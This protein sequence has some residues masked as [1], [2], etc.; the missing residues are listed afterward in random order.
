MTPQEWGRVRELFEELVD[1][2]AAEVQRR[3]DATGATDP[4]T[5]AQVRSLLDH[6][7]HA[8][9]FLDPA[10]L[11]VP[12]LD[13]VIETG[14]E[15]GPYIVVREIGH[16]GMGRVYLARDTRLE[17]MVC[18]KVLRHE[19]STDPLYRERLR[20]EARLAASLTDPGICAVYALE[21]LDSNVYVVTE[22]VE[23]HTL[24]EEIRPGS[25]PSAEA[26]IQTARSLA[27]GLA[28][29]HAK[30]ITHRDLK[31]EN[32]MRGADGRL[33]ILDFG[34]ARVDDA[35]RQGRMAATLPGTIVGTPAYM[36]PEQL[37]GKPADPRSDVFALGVV[38]YEY[39]TATHPFAAPSALAVAARILEQEPEPLR[40][41]RP[42]LP[43][44]FSKAIDR[45]L[46]KEAG[47]RFATAADL[48]NA[49]ENDAASVAR[50]T[51]AG[52]T[53]WK[54]HQFATI[55]IYL[56]A[57]GLAWQIKE[58]EP[59]APGRWAFLAIAFLAAFGGILRGHLLF[60]ESAHPHRLGLERART[61]AACVTVDLAMTIV[62]LFGAFL[63]SAS[64]PVVSA[65]T[66]GLAVTI[67]AATVF[68]EPATS[69][70]T[71]ETDE[72]ELRD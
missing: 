11:D 65:L 4:E 28:A 9:S 18:I 14:A 41:R 19:F 15:I 62:L 53:W 37:T 50:P 20:R 6:H 8:G 22:F 46:T 33:K 72:Q 49:L 67:A 32:I 64:R 40:R 57:C 17:R 58:W 7:S 71:F 26:V 1:R 43:Q 10:T 27:T 52:R 31:P 23:G 69:A 45:C 12:V 5:S 21:E 63:V 30:G 68:I 29:A 2:D 24:R 61:R 35:A 70:A 42:D 38:L 39:A 25:P 54:V 59:V 16:G 51:A 36:S 48:L 56:A 44:S 34:L 66:M 3:L 47:D 60:T 55:G 13:D